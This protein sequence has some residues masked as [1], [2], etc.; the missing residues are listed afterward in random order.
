M[1]SGSN[2]KGGCE[3]SSAR[4]AYFP[5]R[6]KIETTNSLTEEKIYLVY[7]FNALFVVSA[8]DRSVQT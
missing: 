2:G 7:R 6:V 1:V 4:Y 3:G 5:V 8:I